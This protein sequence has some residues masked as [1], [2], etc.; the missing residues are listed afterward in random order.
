MVQN[1]VNEIHRHT[2][3]VYLLVTFKV[4]I[5]IYSTSTN[6]KGNQTISPTSNNT[7]LKAFF[8]FTQ[9]FFT[10]IKKYMQM[11]IVVFSK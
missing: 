10:S 9:L 8:N 11:Y 2:C 3:K 5:C 4:N 7:P 1:K 6:L